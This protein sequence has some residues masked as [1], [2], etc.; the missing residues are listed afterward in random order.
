M[1]ETVTRAEFDNLKNEIAQMKKEM[2]PIDDILTLDD[3]EDIQNYE[4][5]KKEGKL[6]SHED[7]LKELEL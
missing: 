6:I 3:L 1:T 7:L 5:E 4:K 2:A